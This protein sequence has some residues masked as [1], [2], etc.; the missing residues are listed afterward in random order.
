MAI[1][2]SLNDATN[3]LWGD[4]HEGNDVILVAYITSN[5]MG[6]GAGLLQILN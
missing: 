3:W 5:D 6:S 4:I 1:H 2:G